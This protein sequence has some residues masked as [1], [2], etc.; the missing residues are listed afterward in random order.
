MLGEEGDGSGPGFGQ[1]GLVLRMVNSGQAALTSVGA[2]GRRWG[3][4]QAG[5]MRNGDVKKRDQRRGKGRLVTILHVYFF[6][7]DAAGV[8]AGSL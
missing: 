8:M 4:I 7:E 2:G 6:S 5:R 3:T 1:R